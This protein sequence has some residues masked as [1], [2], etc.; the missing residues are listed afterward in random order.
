[1]KARFDALIDGERFLSALWSAIPIG[2]FSGVI[3][4]MYVALMQMKIRSLRA[5]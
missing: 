4:I 2:M 5:R 3:W 1:M